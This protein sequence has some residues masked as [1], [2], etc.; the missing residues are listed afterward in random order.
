MNKQTDFLCIEEDFLLLDIGS[1]TQDVLLAHANMNYENWTR[2]VLPS[3]AMLTSKKIQNCT[4]AQK[5]LVLIGTNMGGG[6]LPAIKDHLAANFPVI[7]T[8]KAAYSLYD[9]LSRVEDMGVVLVEAEKIQ[10]AIAGRPHDIVELSDFSQ[11]FW[12]DYLQKI[13]MT[14]PQKILI[15]AQDHGVH[16]NVGNRTGRFQLWKEAL[17]AS[18]NPIHWIFRDVPAPY[19]RLQAIQED[20]QA[21]FVADTGTAALL[22]AL[23]EHEIRERSRRE[24]ILIVNVG[25]SHVIAFLVYQNAVYGI[26]EHHTDMHT[27]VSLMKDLAEFRLGWLPHE[28]VRESGGHGCIF[29]DIP[30]RA[31]G[32]RPT[33]ILGPRR[34]LLLGGGQFVAPQGDMMLAG[35]FGLLYG[36]HELYK[37]DSA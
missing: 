33:Y 19:T 25:N 30:A 2:F 10:E 6:F 16:E 17:H 14:I 21:F 34:D 20:S 8:A 18:N 29:G 35:A 13:G 26:Y 5:L 15:A 22:G 1:G 24:G 37:Q 12:V 7:A 3:A 9:N 32:F 28:Q 31:E 36:Y 27:T 11:A 23:S 4:A